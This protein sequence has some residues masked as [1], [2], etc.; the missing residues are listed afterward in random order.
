[1]LKQ[2]VLILSLTTILLVGCSTSTGF[3]RSNAS[4]DVTLRGNN[5][6]I[7]KA[8]AIGV[9]RGFKLFGII[10]IA[11]PNYADAK[12]SLY[13]SIGESVEGRSIAL[14]NQT[15]DKSSIY[16]IIFSIQKLTISAD[17]VEFNAPPS[18]FLKQ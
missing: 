17:I 2:I 8:G 3:F 5:Y 14:A 4:S 9:S 15:E 7:V 12:S 6:K 13:S 11:R 1:M 10:P 16:L 18:E